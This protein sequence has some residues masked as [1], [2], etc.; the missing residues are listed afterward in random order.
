[1]LDLVELDADH[2]GRPF[3]T[4][5][6]ASDSLELNAD[7][8]PALRAPRGARRAIPDGLAEG[9]CFDI[10]S[11]WRLRART[12]MRRP[13]IVLRFRGRELVRDPATQAL[14]AR[15]VDETQVFRDEDGRYAPISG[16]NP[17]PDP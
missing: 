11:T 6:V 16:R 12:G 4:T 5:R 1:V 7:C 15:T 10:A 14:E 8:A 17:T 13:D 9:L 3:P 2:A